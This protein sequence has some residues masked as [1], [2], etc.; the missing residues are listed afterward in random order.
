MEKQYRELMTKYESLKSELETNKAKILKEAKKEA[1][2]IVEGSN[3]LIENTIREIKEAQADK[4]KTKLIREKLNAKKEDTSKP[5]NQSEAKTPPKKKKEKPKKD[6]GKI[7]IGNRVRIPPQTMVGEVVEMSGSDAMVS[8]GSVIMKV[9]VKK[10]VNVGEE[11]YHEKM[12]IRRKSYRHIVNDL[13]D[14][15]ANFKLS[16]DLRGKRAEEAQTEVQR[17]IDEALLLS[18]KE[19]KILH[20]KGNGILRDVI[21]DQLRLIPEV[22]RYG[23]EKVEMG[24]TGI[25]VVVLK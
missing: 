11:E 10:L 17:Y 8:F 19:V 22:K 3:K 20:G 25:T 2:Q 6:A 1:R 9:P 14:K 23:D 18:V 4:E 15:M 12:L 16:L 21:R 7:L 13:N 24:G 5:A